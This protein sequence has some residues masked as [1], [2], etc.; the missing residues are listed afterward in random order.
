M[1]APSCDDALRLQR[2]AR[3]QLRLG[4][5]VRSVQNPDREYV[6]G[7]RGSVDCAD[8]DG[9]SRCEYV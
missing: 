1:L 7:T 2:D 4:R 9:P 8:G 3:E 5:Q 6:V